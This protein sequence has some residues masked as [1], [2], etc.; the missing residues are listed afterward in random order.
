MN[1]WETGKRKIDADSVAGIAKITNCNPAWLLTGEGDP[2]Y[3]PGRSKSENESTIINS[4]A[5]EVKLKDKDEL[6][7]VWRE[8]A[9]IAEARLSKYEDKLGN[10]LDTDGENKKNVPG[11]KGGDTYQQ[12][13]KGTGPPHI[14][15]TLRKRSCCFSQMQKVWVDSPQF[16][17][18]PL[19]P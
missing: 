2:S 17:A 6:I 10:P 19:F 14:L 1:Y 5:V 16:S 8:R 13:R 15:Q 18:I 3:T 7:E 11:K 9:K 4:G 12:P